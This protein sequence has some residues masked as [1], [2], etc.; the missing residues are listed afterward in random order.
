MDLGT[1]LGLPVKQVQGESGL[2]F[3]I[4]DDTKAPFVWEKTR[5]IALITDVIRWLEDGELAR[6]NITWRSIGNLLPPAPI[7]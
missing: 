4:R 6:N 3:G 2:A 1:Q 5:L 7:R